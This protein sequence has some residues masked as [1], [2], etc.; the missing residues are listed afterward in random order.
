MH[1]PGIPVA[2]SFLTPCDRLHLRIYW[3]LILSVDNLNC[4]VI[5]KIYVNCNYRV[6]SFKY[7][8]PTVAYCTQAWRRI[9]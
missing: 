7:S 5:R 2:H 6:V 8:V 9:N 3:V 4:N 1:L